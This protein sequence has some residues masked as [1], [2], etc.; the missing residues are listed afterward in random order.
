VKW[1]DEMIQTKGGRKTA[2]SHHE[3]FPWMIDEER[4]NEYATWMASRRMPENSRMSGHAQRGH[5]KVAPRR[6]HN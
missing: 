4:K 5:W 3:H 2:K 6:S 1:R